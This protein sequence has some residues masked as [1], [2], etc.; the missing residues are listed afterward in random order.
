MG[1]GVAR[2]GLALPYLMS[3][4]VS[5]LYAGDD[6]RVPAVYCFDAGERQKE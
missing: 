1:R 6:G 3:L 4:R 2:I 5:E